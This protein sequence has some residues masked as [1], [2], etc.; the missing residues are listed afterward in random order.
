MGGMTRDAYHHGDLPHAVMAAALDEMAGG[1]R[2][3]VNFNRIARQLGVSH[4]AIYRHFPTKQALIDALARSGFE[5]LGDILGATLAERADAST[6]DRI[7]ALARAFITFAVDQPM[8]LRLMFS[9]AAADRQRDPALKQA[10]HGTIGLLQAEVER[11]A[12]EGWVEADEVYDVTRFFW[13]G[14]H[15]IATLRI[16]GQ[17]D[18]MLADDA[19]FDRLVE[20]SARWLARGV[21]AT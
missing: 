1:D 5:R 15:G 11:A 16:E 17:F 7:R 8:L 20:R 18:G 9:G 10:A 19:E 2:F 3:A 13:A 21:S 12:S 6:R 14:M 4:A